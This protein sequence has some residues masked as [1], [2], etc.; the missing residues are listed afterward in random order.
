[1]NKGKF[2]S[3]QSKKPKAAKIIFTAF[4]GFSG[5]EEN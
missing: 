3:S 4:A 2:Y 5:I 1:M